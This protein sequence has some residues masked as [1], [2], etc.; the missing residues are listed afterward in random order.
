MFNV[1]RVGSM[2]IW[3]GIASGTKRNWEKEKPHSGPREVAKEERKEKDG[4]VEEKEGGREENKE[5]G[6]VVSKG[7][8]TR[9]EKVGRKGDIHMLRGIKGHVGIV[10]R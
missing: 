10:G 7:K 6:R 8:E 4:R 9:E 3:L 2:D 5:K 1:M